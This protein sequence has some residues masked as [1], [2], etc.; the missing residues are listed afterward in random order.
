MSIHSAKGLEFRNVVLQ[1]SDFGKISENAEMFY[2]A[3]TRAEKRL[4][5][6]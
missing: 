3:C 1:K 6:V 4:F 5:F 2:V